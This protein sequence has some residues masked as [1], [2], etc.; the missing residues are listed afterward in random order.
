MSK[1]ILILDNANYSDWVVYAES[2]MVLG[3]YMEIINGTAT[4]PL[5]ANTSPAVKCWFKH[6]QQAHAKLIQLA[7]VTF[8]LNH[9]D[10]PDLVNITEPF[11]FLTGH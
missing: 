7:A 5:G 9:K 4:C 2:V 11:S 3:D 1:P 10:S 8:T 6:N